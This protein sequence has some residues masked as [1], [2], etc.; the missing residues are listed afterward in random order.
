MLWLGAHKTRHAERPSHSHT[1]QLDPPLRYCCSRRCRRC[2]GS[3]R[4]SAGRAAACSP[5]HGAPPGPPR[6]LLVTGGCREGCQ[7]SAAAQA[8]SLTQAP[9]GTL[10]DHG[11]RRDSAPSLYSSPLRDRTL[12]VAPSWLA[13]TQ[14]LPPPTDSCSLLGCS[15]LSCWGWLGP[16][17][18]RLFGWR[19]LTGR[20]G[21]GSFHRLPFCRAG[22]RRFLGSRRRLGV[23]VT[24]RQRGT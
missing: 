14:A 17:R 20:L 4:I 2:P 8:Q 21:F 24:L 22:R 12:D 13:W 7:R 19:G 3:P 16:R 18:R 1:V 9:L 15:G 6:T 5:P 10:P 11:L 23:A